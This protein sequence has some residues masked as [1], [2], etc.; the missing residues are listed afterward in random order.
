MPM[1]GASSALHETETRRAWK[2]Q[3]DLSAAQHAGAQG[4]EPDV[5]DPIDPHALLQLGTTGAG[6]ELYSERLMVTAARANRFLS[7]LQCNNPR[8]PRRNILRQTML[9]PPESET[10]RAERSMHT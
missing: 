9:D 2:E 6:N 10:G 3:P 7:L 5:V 4:A 8:R 1:A